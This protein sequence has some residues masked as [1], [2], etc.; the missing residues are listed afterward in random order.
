MACAGRAS[1]GDVR[2]CWRSAMLMLQLVWIFAVPPFRGS[3]EFDHAYRAARSPVAS[4]WRRP[5]APPA[6]PAPGRRRPRTSSAPPEP[7]CADLQYTDRR[8]LHRPE[9][10]D[11]HDPG[12]DRRR[13]LP[14]ALL[15]SSSALPALPFDGTA[16]LYVMR[17][18]G[19]AAV[20]GVLRARRLVA[21]RLLGHAPAGPTSRWPWR[22]PRWSSTA[23]SC[24]AP[25]GVEMTAGPGAVVRADRAGRPPTD[26]ARPPAARQ[27][28]R[29]RRALLVTLRSFGP[30]WCLLILAHG[31]GRRPRRPGAPAPRSS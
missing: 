22:A 18:A 5:R 11:G 27:S 4:G 8:R 28:G 16:A 29:W 23:R 3:D 2:G 25:N 12:G 14:P 24:P 10:G 15:R 26:P 30:L 13:A 19:G 6:G 17:L 1:L 7:Q 9:V 21:T 20:L 31:P